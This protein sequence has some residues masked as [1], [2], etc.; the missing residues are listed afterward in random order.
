MATLSTAP[1]V[2]YRMP[3]HARVWVY[4]SALPFTTGQLEML[5]M[6]G[7]EFAVSWAA[8]GA[9][10]AAAVDVLHDHFVVIAVDERQA[11]ASGCSIDA[12]VQFIKQLEQELGHSLTDRMLV[13]YQKDGQVRAC[14][15][16]EVEAMLKNGTLSPDTTVFN[17]LV[18][19]VGDLRTSFQVPLKETWLARYC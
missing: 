19:T 7:A 16:L 2:L 18:A 8:H 14:R 10:L 9:Q 12:S 5:A 13:L 3:A 4:K 15:A 11:A 17:D 6:R 1:S